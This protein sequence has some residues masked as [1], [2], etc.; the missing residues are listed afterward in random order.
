MT[1]ASAPAL[2]RL[3]AVST[4][5]IPPPTIRNPLNVCLT[6][7]TISGVTLDFAPEP[8][9]KYTNL[10]PRNYAANEYAAAIFGFSNGIPLA[11]P[12]NQADVP[13]PITKYAVGSGSKPNLATLG[14]ANAC[15]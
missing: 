8:A 14:A 9:S 2:T 3:S 5:L 12:T 1:K 7:F 13:S 11:E 6:V 4:S 10:I 15:A